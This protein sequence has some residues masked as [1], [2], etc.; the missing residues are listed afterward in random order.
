MDLE[1]VRIFVH[2]VQAGGFSRAAQTL[3][4]PKSTVSRSISRLE[5]EAGARLLIRTTRQVSLTET[6]RR[7]YEDCLDPVRS[8]EEAR[9]LLQGRDERMSGV[10]RITAPDDFGTQVIS[11][12]VGML[13]REYPGL[14][15]ELAYTN[16]VLDLVRHGYDFALRIGPLTPSRLKARRLGELVPCLVAAPGYLQARPPIRAPRDLADHDCLAIESASFHQSWSLR[17]G[18]RQVDVAIRP[19]VLLNQVVSVLGL[20]LQGIGV[21]L[22][23]NHLCREALRA[24]QLRRVLPAWQGEPI[25]LSLVSPLGTAASGRLRLVAERLAAAI[26]QAIAFDA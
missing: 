22:L 9:R 5:R 12:I 7:F 3:G 25:A 2:V 1:P 10:I 18:A 16:E 11:P 20:A 4:L 24:G 21:A 19:R 26:R 8:I 14:T 15:F 13:L 6:G 17:S 23:P